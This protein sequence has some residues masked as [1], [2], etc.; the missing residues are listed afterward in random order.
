MASSAY[1]PGSNEGG[2]DSFCA[3]TSI[4]ILFSTGGTLFGVGIT[5]NGPSGAASLSNISVTFDYGATGFFPADTMNTPSPTLPSGAQI[6]YDIGGKQLFVGA[7][8]DP[9]ATDAYNGTFDAS[10]PGAPFASNTPEPASW[11][12]LLAGFGLVGLG[13]RTRIRAVAKAG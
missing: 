2:D 7:P 4:E 13:L 1:C 3:A 11:L 10:M 6:G 9:G 5:D 12:L 8:D